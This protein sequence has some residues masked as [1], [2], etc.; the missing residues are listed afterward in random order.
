MARRRRTGTTRQRSDC[1]TAARRVSGVKIFW[2]V[3]EIKDAIFGKGTL[4]LRVK[5]ERVFT[6]R[7]LG[8]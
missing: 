1:L 5:W 2:D 6:F 8:F 4:L 3:S 7:G